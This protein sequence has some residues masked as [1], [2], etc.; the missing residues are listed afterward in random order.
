MTATPPRNI[1]L[2]HPAR[3]ISFSPGPAPL[4]S[5]AHS[6]RTA[7]KAYTG[8]GQYHV[9][10]TPSTSPQGE[11]IWATAV[12]QQ[13]TPSNV[14]LQKPAEDAYTLVPV[15]STVEVKAEEEV[16]EAEKI[17][18][19]NPPPPVLEYKMID[20]Q[21]YEAKKSPPGS[22]KSF[23]S[24][25]QYRRTAEDGTSHRVMVHY[26]RSRKTMEQ[27]CKQF[28]MNEKV[29]GFDLEWMTEP[30]QLSK[31]KKNVS[32]I[33]LASPSRIGLFHVAVFADK[34]DM[35]GPS[36]KSIMEDPDI[37]K[38]GVWVKGDATRVR[39]HLDIH[40][41]GLIELSHLYK[42]V[43]YSRTRQYHKIDRRLVPLAT[44][45][46][47]YLHLPLFKGQDVRTSDWSKT[48]N[49][50]QVKYAGSD[51]Y[52]GVHLY[53]TLDH[54]RKQLDPCPPLPH[55]AELGL[56]IQLAE[57]VKRNRPDNTAEGDDVVT[58]NGGTSTSSEKCLAA[59]IDDISIED[60]GITSPVP[61]AKIA[62]PKSPAR[63][64]DSRIEV[65]ED[66]L[67]EQFRIFQVEPTVEEY[68]VELP[69]QRSNR[70]YVI[71][72]VKVLNYHEE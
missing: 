69:V 39:N 52:A 37:I 26:C 4:I 66:R 50:D 16:K 27:V 47:E 11:D 51:A 23:W 45:V 40:S 13:V 10:T 28:F 5:P 67:R 57:G 17:S 53:A 8:A 24:Y 72:P 41:R 1:R 2:W 44:Q 9:A 60:K 68:V 38:A 55:H 30:T 70:M 43:T 32:L 58:S 33:Q 12:A 20:D 31:L 56:A 19:N 14:N 6:P 46:E 63:P 36:F 34:E 35:V 71:R 21:F 61:K 42:L 59:A 18:T 15:S 25:K 49:M 65:A 7:A 29:L 62:T 3:G 48:L 64:K 22:P 54:Y